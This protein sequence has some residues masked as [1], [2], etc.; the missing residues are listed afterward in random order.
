MNF[1]VNFFL[2]KW[3][4]LCFFRGMSFKT[5]WATYWLSEIAWRLS[6]W[7]NGWAV[8]AGLGLAVMYYGV[9]KARDGPGMGF[10]V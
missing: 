2:E 9:L 4:G 5:E 8:L 10:A 7:A 1:F 3:T 6:Y